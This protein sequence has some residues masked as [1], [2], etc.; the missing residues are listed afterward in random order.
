MQ[1][2]QN[3]TGSIAYSNFVD[4]IKTKATLKTYLFCLNAYLAYRKTTNLDTLA[5][6]DLEK[7]R[8]AEANIKQY[9]MHVAL[10]HGFRK[11]ANTQMVQSDMKGA[12]KEMLLGHSIGLDDKCYRSTTQ[13]LLDEYLKAVHSLTISEE[14]RL[15]R[16]ME[17]LT[18]KADDVAILRGQLNELRAIVFK[19][20]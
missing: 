14:K 16:K 4:S 17:E 11:F 9:I 5:K 3:S 8:L 6:A 7:P 10:A 18:I 15:R 20:K 12:A 13:Q 1:A 19:K 2:L